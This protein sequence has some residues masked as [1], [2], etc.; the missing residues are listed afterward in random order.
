MEDNSE[1]I[2]LYIRLN[3]RDH[4]LAKR[5]YADSY[6]LDGNFII[7]HKILREISDATNII[8]FHFLSDFKFTW[9]IHS[10]KK[11]HVLEL[12]TKLFPNSVDSWNSLLSIYKQGLNSDKVI[13]T[14]KKVLTV[15]P[16]SHLHWKELALEYFNVGQYQNA[17]E[18][19]NKF[20]ELFPKNEQMI[21][22]HKKIQKYL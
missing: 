9:I 20:L 8:L 7:M 3:S 6:V 12:I 11:A 21:E 22:L 15:K 18:A 1:F 5:K 13:T 16:N 10:D 17:L 4:K 2:K 14:L 19:C